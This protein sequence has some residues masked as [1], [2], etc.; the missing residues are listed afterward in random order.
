MPATKSVYTARVLWGH[1]FGEER[2]LLHLFT[3]KRDGEKLIDPRVA[4]YN[5]PN[6][7]EAAEKWARQKSDEGREVF[8]C[9]HLLTRPERKKENAAA[10]QTLWVDL[11][12]TRIPN[13]SFAPSAAVETSPGKYHAYW[14]LEEPIPPETAERLN[15]RLAHKVGA[16]A[17]GFDLSQLLRVPGT[18]N[19]KYP[20]APEVEILHLDLEVAYSPRSL[21]EQLPKVEERRQAQPVESRIA[22]GGRNKELTSIAGTMRRR[23]L[24]EEELAAALLAVNDRRCDP[25]LEEE[26]VRKIAR[27]VAGYEPEK[28][29]P[30][31]LSGPHSRSRS[32]Y[33]D[34]NGRNG[35]IIHPKKLLRAVSFTRREKP[36]PQN[37][38]VE[39]LLPERLPATLYGTG[40]LAKSANVLHLGLSVAFAGVEDWHGLKIGTCPVI[41]LDFE[42]N[43][44]TQLGR[45]QEIA[46]GAGWP[47]VPVNFRYIEAVGFTADEV[48]RFTV[49][50]LEE[51]KRALVIIDSYGFA[52][53]GESERSGDVLDFH[54]RYIEPIQA[55]GGTPL[56][57][58][59]V[60]RVIKGERPEDKDPFGSAYKSYA[61]RS[62]IHVTGHVGD[63]GEIYTTFTHKKC[64]VGPQ[65][66]PFTIVTKFSRDSIT[67]ERSSEVVRP[68]VAPTTEQKV[69]VVLDKEDLTAAEISARIAAKEKT[70]ANAVTTL[71]KEGVV[72]ETGEKREGAHVLSLNSSRSR[73]YKGM[74]MGT[75]DE[76]ALSG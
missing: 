32:P 72:V 73:T 76:E 61:S 19:Y 1:V 60:S 41:F 46:S 44:A 65:L 22:S 47:D 59:H 18:K 64:N 5:Y 71:K 30:I 36:P 11:D 58:D 33:I 51:L 40:G 48:F 8:F 12:G 26:E 14:L 17:S 13:G 52:L 9:A 45:A 49:E 34:G 69:V 57:V 55:A 6:A 31:N 74:G 56:T 3:A 38:L 7:V 15:K 62:V 37:F 70:V 10:V 35:G 24:E 67:F 63:T 28:V 16:D 4:H 68:P 50:Q 54:R 20:E 2:G 53:Q 43:E 66:S 23:G 42:M 75:A 29:V 25:P 39:G 27:S 21:E